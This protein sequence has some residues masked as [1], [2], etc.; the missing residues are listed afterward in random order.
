M[1]GL[2]P[3]RETTTLVGTGERGLV[4]DCYDLGH[5]RA[6]PTKK[7]AL[8]SGPRDTAR[9]LAT[10]C[11]PPSAVCA[12]RVHSSKARTVPMPRKEKSR[13]I[14]DDDD[15]FDTASN[16]MVRKQVVDHL[17]RVLNAGVDFD[18]DEGKAKGDG[19]GAEEV[20]ALKGPD[21]ASSSALT[22]R[23]AV[24]ET[25]AKAAAVQE[26]AVAAA[27]RAAADAAKVEAEA[28][29]Q[30][31][32]EELERRLKAEAEAA[33]MRA[34]DAA[35]AEKDRAVKVALEAQPTELREELRKAREESERLLKEA[36]DEARAAA[37]NRG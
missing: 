5:R 1:G 18:D 13:G 17:P 14:V 2:L 30:H 4:S 29:K 20:L 28:A 21:S 37:S 27:A 25:W 33:L 32:L 34:W 7:R 9:A 15:V 26:R 23:T 10:Y 36:R 6:S 11:S 3:F 12:L 24:D 31:A 8:H 19:D 16:A 22:V 35:T